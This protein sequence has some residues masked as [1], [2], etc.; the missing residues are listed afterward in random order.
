MKKKYI[1]LALFFLVNTASASYLT[2][3]TLMDFVRDEES[4]KNSSANSM[5][6]GYIAGV[7]D[8]FD[9]MWDNKVCIPNNAPL[10]QLK[11]VVVKYLKSNPE[12]WAK[13]ADMLVY[14]ALQSAF[15]CSNK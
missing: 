12:R 4:G 10:G 1:V 3:N 5:L 6:L 2:G 11:A 15:P 9:G 7:H 13:S 8:V 14:A